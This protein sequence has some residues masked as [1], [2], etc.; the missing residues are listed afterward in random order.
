MT[1]LHDNFVAQPAPHPDEALELEFQ[2]AEARV[3][4]LLTGAPGAFAREDVALLLSELRR[5]Q[6]CLLYTSRCV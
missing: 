3:S 4:A 1:T 6:T 5:R 2:R